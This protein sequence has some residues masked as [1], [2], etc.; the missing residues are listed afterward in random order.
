M[1]FRASQGLRNG[2][3][4]PFGYRAVEKELV[5]YAREKEIVELAFKQFIETHSTLAVAK[6]L[7]DLGL[8]NKENK[9]WDCK[10]ILWMLQRSIYTGDMTWCGKVFPGTHPAIISR[11]TFELAQEIFKK[12]RKPT[13][14]NAILQ[15]LLFCGHCNAPMTPNYAVNRFKVKYYY[16]LCTTVTKANKP[17]TCPH[18]RVSLP[19][20]QEVVL[21]YILELTQEKAF[22]SFGNRIQIHNDTITQKELTMAT[23]IAQ[24]N[25]EIV[26]LKVKKDR[27]FDTLMTQSLLSHERKM[28]NERLKEI[29]QELGKLKAVLHKQEFEKLS[30]VE[31]KI[32]STHFRQTLSHFAEHLE[33]WDSK[34]IHCALQ[35]L[36]KEIHYHEKHLVVQFKSLAWVVQIPF[37]KAHLPP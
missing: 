7:N 34:T 12:R 20:I 32:D 15:K 24:L 18:K 21:N 4:T 5:P 6:F 17:S 13:K 25:D 27:Y 3:T 28:G 22:R 31:T 10:R 26:K 2:G 30:L 16:Y 35:S 14:T 9:P 1:Q 33:K 36:I 8:R 11:Q 23:A 29:D 19:V 37:S